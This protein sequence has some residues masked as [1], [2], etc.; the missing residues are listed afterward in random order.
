M[1][2]SMARICNHLAVFVR[3][4]SYLTRACLPYTYFS[5]DIKHAISTRWL[6]KLNGG[7]THFPHNL[8]STIVYTFMIYK[9]EKFLSL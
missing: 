3:F 2:T 5:Q 9:K 4:V 6:A 8:W 1:A 7:C